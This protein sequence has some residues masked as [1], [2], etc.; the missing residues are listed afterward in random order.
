MGAGGH[1]VRKR[2]REMGLFRLEE[3][4][5]RSWLAAAISFL[6][7]LRDAQWMDVSQGHEFHCRKFRFEFLKF[8]TGRMVKNQHRPRRVVESPALELFAPSLDKAFSSLIQLW[9]RVCSEQGTG[10]D[11]FRDPFQ[12]Q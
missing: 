7:F 5:Q 9:K 11:P 10:P 4:G 12:P 3:M 2:L 6:V 1:H 8:F